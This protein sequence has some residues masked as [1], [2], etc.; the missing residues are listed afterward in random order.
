MAIAVPRGV[1]LAVTA[2]PKGGI[3]IW[4]PIKPAVMI[5]N[6]VPVVCSWVVDQQL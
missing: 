1:E 5:G 2:V 3:R 6:P 4:N